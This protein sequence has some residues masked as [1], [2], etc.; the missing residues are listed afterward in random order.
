MRIGGSGLRLGR[1]TYYDV[2]EE[3][4]P[5]LREQVR[6][7]TEDAASGQLPWLTNRKRDYLRRSF[8]LWGL[9]R[10]M[11]RALEERGALAYREEQVSEHVFEE[12]EPVV[13]E[14]MQVFANRRRDFA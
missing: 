1:R 9:T 12:L 7:I 8:S 5:E 14:A 3:V 2:L 6:E 4:T 10:D 13:E 11:L